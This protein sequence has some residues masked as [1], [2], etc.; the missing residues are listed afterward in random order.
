M[1]LQK[2]IVL[3]TR[4]IR[5]VVFAFEG[6]IVYDSASHDYGLANDDSR[7]TGIEHI[8]VTKDPA[9]RHPFFTIPKQDLKLAD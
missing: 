3:R 5:N 1:T 8:S 2:Y 4:E 9:G 6:E 7:V